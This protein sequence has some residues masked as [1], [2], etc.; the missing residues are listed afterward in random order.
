LPFLTLKEPLY[1]RE[2]DTGQFFN[3][4]LGYVRPVVVWFLF[5]HRAAPLKPFL[6]EQKGTEKRDPLSPKTIKNLH[7]VLHKA[8]KQALELGYIKFNPSP[9]PAS[10]QGWSGWK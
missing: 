4:M 5:R 2:Q 3:F 8:L 7:G 1:F 10:F 9:T 6:A